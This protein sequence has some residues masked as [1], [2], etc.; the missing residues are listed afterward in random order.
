MT[1]MPNPVRCAIYTRK[2]TEDG[3]EQ[4][5]NSLHAQREACEAYISSQR[6]EGWQLVPDAYD[7]G[8][9]SGGTMERPGLKALMQAVENGLVDVIVVYKVDRLTRSLADFAK[10]VEIL[11]DRKASF[12]SITQAFNTTT[13]MGRLTLNVLLSF[14]Q[15]ER[16]VTGERI[17]DKIAASKKKGM[18]MGGP[19]PLGYIVE[20]RKLVTQPEEAKRVRTIMRRYL[21]SKSAPALLV[22]LESEGILTKVQQR[23][24]GPHRGGIPFRRG[25]LFHLLKNPV[26]RGKIVHK[27]EIYNGEHQ[28]IVD[29]ELWEA[30]QAKLASA[31]PPR[32]RPGNDPQQALLKGLLSDSQ[33]RP[34]VPTYATK[35]VRRYRY[36]ETRR[37]LTGT[38][39]A[40]STRYAM[41]HLERHVA[42]H[43]GAL[44]GDQYALR[45]IADLTD[46]ASLRMMF[47]R[48][49]LH[50]QEMA[51]DLQSVIHKLVRNISFAPDRMI[52]EL[53]P[54]QFGIEEP[55][56]CSW[57]HEIPLLRKKPFREAKLRIN[58]NDDGP[59]NIDPKLIGL[60]ADAMSAQKLVLASPGV[61]LQKIAMR[62]GRCRKQLTQLVKLSW[63][64]PRIVEAIVEGRQPSMLSRKRIMD[65]DLPLAWGDQE[66]LLGV[67]SLTK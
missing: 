59:A 24:S 46:G 6:H 44:L 17:R 38:D 11:D 50:R 25:S 22:Q 39:K 42:E 26:Y 27:G 63:V 37:D 29:A 21:A 12:V 8:G 58:S 67:S 64:S 40:E 4:E 45:R 2:S 62:E 3:L 53:D 47:A 19:V 51:K 41:V 48:A 56:T 57:T 7:D 28:A 43:I 30:V 49:E 16:E 35:G 66:R 14:A 55:A 32:K 61:P 1:T 5:F 20:N 33:G 15:F 60:L 54:N 31:A 36:Y 10:I 23:V 13:S 65:T 52:V 9:Y 34:M 18:W